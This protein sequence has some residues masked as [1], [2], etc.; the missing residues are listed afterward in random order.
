MGT[1]NDSLKAIGAGYRIGCVSKDD[2]AFAL[3]SHQENKLERNRFVSTLGQFSPSL[4]TIFLWIQQVYTQDGYKSGN[5]N[6]NDI[7]SN[8]LSIERSYS[9]L[10]QEYPPTFI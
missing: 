4:S 6:S 3:R 2:Y 5:V 9:T 8:I 7:V 10:L 1:M